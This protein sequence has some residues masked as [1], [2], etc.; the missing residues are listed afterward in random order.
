M[1]VNKAKFRIYPTPGQEQILSQ[2]FGASRFV[3]NH[4]LRVRIDYYAM[5]KDD[6][7]AAQNILTFGQLL[8]LNS[9]AGTAQTQRRGSPATRRNVEPGSPPLS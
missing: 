7:N 3:Y 6:E 5:H 8:D 4:F 9:R 1:L 2:Q